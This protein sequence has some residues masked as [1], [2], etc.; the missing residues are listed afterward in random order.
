MNI[1]KEKIV[2]GEPLYEFSKKH[3]LV[4]EETIKQFKGYESNELV[5]INL[6]K[7]VV[8]NNDTYN[9]IL[10]MIEEGD[11]SFFRLS[12]I[13]NGDIGTTITIPL[14]KLVNAMNIIPSF[15]SNDRFEHLQSLVSTKTMINKFGEEEYIVDIE[16][17]KCVLKEK[18]LFALVLDEALYSKILMN[19]ENSNFINNLT[20]K[21]VVYMFIKLFKEK[22]FLNRYM[23]SNVVKSRIK[24]LLH[25]QIV[26]V[27]ALNTLLTTEDPIQNKININP[28]LRDAVFR[29]MP[30]NMTLVEKSMYIYMKLCT[31]LTYDPEYFI[32][33]QRGEIAKKHDDINYL[34][35]ITPT[36]NKAVCFEFNAIFG[37]LLSELGINYST[38]TS[39]IDGYGGGHALL[40]YR[41][42]NMLIRADAVTSVLMGDMELVKEGKNPVGLVCNNEN[43]DTIDDFNYY[44]EEMVGLIKDQKQVDNKY[45]LELLLSKYHSLNKDKEVEIPF[46][47]KIELLLK[48]LSKTQ[49]V[50][51]DA[52]GYII[53]SCRNIFHKEAEKN[54]FS[55]IIVKE[56][57]D[58]EAEKVKPLVIFAINDSDFEISTNTIYLAYYPPHDIRKYNHQE[59]QDLV[60]NGIIELKSREIPGIIRKDKTII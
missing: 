41:I 57:T 29:N 25:Y 45:N 35:T 39:I 42:N 16:G 23:F 33:D 15:N 18:Y 14:L 56:N 20:T 59:L 13:K 24:M 30:V 10:E 43:T 11:S 34:S 12:S 47:E 49:M 19:S 8:E 54:M 21:E 1:E 46:T 7:S 37:K 48:N 58:N 31:L 17:K 3:L 40:D 50:G 55:L 6:A 27:Q 26:D 9:Y 60:D 52:L 4:T 32:M 38:C 36:N 22:E 2:E 53:A 51:V 28:E 44:L 5:L